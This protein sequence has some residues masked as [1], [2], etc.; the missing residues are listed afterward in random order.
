VDGVGHLGG[1][2]RNHR[3]TGSKPVLLVKNL[4]SPEILLTVALHEKCAFHETHFAI[5]R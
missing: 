3:G 2:S 4:E 1:A 5:S